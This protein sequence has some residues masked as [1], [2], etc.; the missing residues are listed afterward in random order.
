MSTINWYPGIKVNVDPDAILDFTFD[1]T[2]WLEGSTIADCEVIAEECEAAVTVQ[3]PTLV[4]IRVQAFTGK[5]S[6]TV[7][8]T[9]VDGQRD[10]FTIKF[11]PKQQ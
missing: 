7:R 1:F 3:S 8:P 9:A 4:R 2:T 10:D 11:N 6:A 5:G